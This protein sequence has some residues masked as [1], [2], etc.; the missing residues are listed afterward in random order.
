MT[1]V[2]LS[3]CLAV[4]RNYLWQQMDTSD[5]PQRRP[6]FA[7]RGPK[8]LSLERLREIRALVGYRR[9]KALLG[10][11]GKTLGHWEM[12]DRMP[13]ATARRAIFLVWVHLRFPGR[14]L[15]E[16][17]IVTEGRFLIEPAPTPLQV[18]PCGVPPEATNDNTTQAE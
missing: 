4:V 18:D 11:P 5:Y 6:D 15:T 9:T 12:A 3:P 16:F 14:L 10:V 2:N 7:C 8:A 17:E 13:S 1:R